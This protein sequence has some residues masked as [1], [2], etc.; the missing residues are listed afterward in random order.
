MTPQP[1]H[2]KAAKK[3]VKKWMEHS[4]LDFDDA[5]FDVAIALA[6]AENGAAW[7]GFDEGENAGGWRAYRD[8]Y[9][10]KIETKYGPRPEV[11]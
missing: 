10:N 9:E 11:K 6:D 3:I 8:Q 1:R 5:L 4:S 7:D 2:I